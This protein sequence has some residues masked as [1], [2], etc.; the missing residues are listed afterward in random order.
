MSEWTWKIVKSWTIANGLV[1]KIA[2]R[3]NSTLKKYSNRA[4]VKVNS[5]LACQCKVNV[6]VI[7]KINKCWQNGIRVNLN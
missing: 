4:V 6:N 5:R 3:S 7:S 2:F 1:E